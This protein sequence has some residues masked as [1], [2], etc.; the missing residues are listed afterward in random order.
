MIDYALDEE[1]NFQR[2]DFLK[3]RPYEEILQLMDKGY[4]FMRRR[5]EDGSVRGAFHT[6]DVTLQGR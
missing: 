5:H 2:G 3:L 4:D 6:S 1:L